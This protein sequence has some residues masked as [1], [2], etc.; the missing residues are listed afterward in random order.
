MKMKLLKINE[1]YDIFEDKKHNVYQVRSGSEL[2][3]IEF[4]DQEKKEI[5]EMALKI[6][7]SK[8]KIDYKLLLSILSRQFSKRKIIEVISSLLNENIIEEIEEKD[9]GNERKTILNLQVKFLNKEKMKGVDL[10]KNIKKTS[11]LILGSSLWLNLL[12]EKAQK[13][14]FEKIKCVKLRKKNCFS[15]ISEYIKKSDFVIVENE[16]P[17]PWVV[18]ELNMKLAELNKPWLLIMGSEGFTI[19]VGP[20]FLGKGTGCYNCLTLRIKSCMESD[21]YSYNEEYENYLKS[22]LKIGTSGGSLVLA[23]DILSSISLIEILK[24]I[25]GISIPVIYKSYISLDLLNYEFQIHHLLKV[26]NCPICGPKFEVMPSP[27]LEPLMLEE[28]KKKE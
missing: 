21:F 3:I 25:T 9:L 8:K 12:K 15:E 18:E 28:E 5:F 26:P 23:Y 10:Q 13:S 24:Y 19:R 20:M 2:M 1:I 7:K 4:E 27:W 14:G 17:A 6:L 11:L 16:R 22:N